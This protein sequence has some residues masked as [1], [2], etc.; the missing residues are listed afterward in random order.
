M[1]KS[2]GRFWVPAWLIDDSLQPLGSALKTFLVIA[3]FAN[4]ERICW[5]SVSTIAECVGMN[6]KTIRKHLRLLV[7]HDLLV[8][9][10][11]KTGGRGRP[12]KYRLK[13][14]GEETAA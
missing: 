13:P 4:K 1:P 7:K 2:T 12:T 3:R 8:T 9:V 14:R 11:G 10:E 5:P 6:E